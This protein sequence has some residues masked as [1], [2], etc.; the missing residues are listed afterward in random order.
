MDIE[1]IKDFLKFNPQIQAIVI[2]KDKLDKISTF[3]TAGIV[4]ITMN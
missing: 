3:R 2:Y 1:E 4:K